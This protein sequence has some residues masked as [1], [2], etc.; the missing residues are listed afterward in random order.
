MSFLHRWIDRLRNRPSQPVFPG[1]HWMMNSAWLCQAVYVAA[2][3]DVA[4]RLRHGPLPIDRLATACDVQAVPLLQV[5]R[6]LAAFGIF[7]TT[8][9]GRWGLNAEARRLLGDDPLSVRPY[10]LVC[11]EQLWSAA[12]R[13]LEQLRTGRTGFEHAHGAPIWSH[14]AAMPTDANV[15]DS[16]MSAVTDIH[17][18]WLTAAYQFSRHR[19]VVDVGSGRGRLLSAMLA[20]APNLRGVWCD[21]AEVLP[22]AR[23]LLADAGVATRCE[24]VPGSFLDKVPAGADLYVIKHVLHDWAD[25]P[26]GTILKNIAA[27]MEPSSTLLVIE[28]LLDHRSGHGGLAKIRDL[29]QMFWTGGR[30]RSRAEFSGLLAPAGLEILGVVDT[31]VADMSLIRVRKRP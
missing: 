18:R 14:Y 20:A 15:F 25:E 13:M 31:P 26:A 5:M 17:V 4:E 1:T 19:R 6:A 24:F 21:R 9:D 3:L 7:S 28:G 8:S 11:G 16:F 10:A 22:A 27:A 30:V 2:K 23:E 29:E 12:G